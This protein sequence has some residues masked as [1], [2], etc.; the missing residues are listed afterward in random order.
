MVIMEMLSD[1]YGWT[2]EQIRAQRQEDIEAYINILHIKSKINKRA[3][4]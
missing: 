4:M 3:K 1:K 2:P